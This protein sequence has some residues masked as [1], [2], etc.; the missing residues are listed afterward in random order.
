MAGGKGGKGGSTGHASNAALDDDVDDRKAGRKVRFSLWKA[1]RV[2][3]NFISYDK[4]PAP[5][6]K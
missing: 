1:K 6:K 4:S 2:K 5:P 3:V